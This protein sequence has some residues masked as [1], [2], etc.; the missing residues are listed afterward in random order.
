VSSGAADGRRGHDHHTAAEDRKTVTDADTD[1]ERHPGEP[2]RGALLQLAALSCGYRGIPVVQEVSLAVRAGE[3]ALVVGPNGAGKST[4]VKAVIGELPLL[5]GAITFD[6]KDV[7]GWS[8]ERRSVGG[9]GYV[10]QSRDVFPTLTV[11]ENLEVGAYRL[12]PRDAKSAIAEMLERFPQLA[13]LRH[14]KARQLSGG[15][16]KLLAIARGLIAN[17]K[18][19]ILDEPTA[20]LAPQIAR[21]VLEEVVVNLAA[22]GHGILLVEQRVALASRVAAQVT[23]LVDGK[24]HY[25]ASGEEFRSL[26]DVGAIFFGSEASPGGEVIRSA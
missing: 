16:R 4:L 10:P 14:R 5:A 2:G 21:L 19:L 13:R 3:I 9:L 11:V 18:L 1:G 23:V 24:V 8:E 12:K 17:P 6:G 15:E 22:T 26:P 20:N 25:A 7:S